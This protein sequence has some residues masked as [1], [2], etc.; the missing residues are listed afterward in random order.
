MILEHVNIPLWGCNLKIDVVPIIET[1]QRH[2][3]AYHAGNQYLSLTIFL[4]EILS[5]NHYPGCFV[6]E[7]LQTAKDKRNSLISITK[8]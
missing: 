3:K 2:Q 8:K 1:K 6:P 4:W 5:F 7:N